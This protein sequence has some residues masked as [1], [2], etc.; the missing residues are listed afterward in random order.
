MCDFFEDIS[1]ASQGAALMEVQTKAAHVICLFLW[2][3][4]TE[5]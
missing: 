3:I 1:V 5:S 4:P 2:I